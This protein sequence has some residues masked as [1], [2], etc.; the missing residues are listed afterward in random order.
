MVCDFLVGT[1]LLHWFLLCLLP[2][3]G[4]QCTDT[5]VELVFVIHS[6][7]R[8][9]PANF[10]RVKDFVSAVADRLSVS[11]AASR[12]GL[13][14]SSQVDL[15]VSSLQEVSSHSA[16]RAAIKRM[17][18]P[19]HD[20]FTGSAIQRATTLFQSPAASVRRVAVVLTD[21]QVEP[22]HSRT[23]E[24]AAAEAHDRGVEVFVVGV[25]NRS[26]PQYEQFHAEVKVMASDPDEEHVFLVEDFHTLHSKQAPPRSQT[27]SA[28]VSSHEAHH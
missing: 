26:D 27:T 20:T 23:V 10:D 22:D 21:H 19:G 24:E 14:L 12:V 11:T 8:A 2:G 16:L 15:V 4:L 5:P 9:G 13:V 6:S 3:C 28:D 17:T 7:E 25:K 1:L 18:W